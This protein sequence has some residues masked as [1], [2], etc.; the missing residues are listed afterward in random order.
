M[1]GV[2]EP[3]RGG[4]A[5]PAALSS[6]AVTPPGSLPAAALLFLWQVSAAARLFV[7]LSVPSPG[8]LKVR[9][10]RAGRVSVGSSSGA[11]PAAESRACRRVLRWQRCSEVGCSP[12]IPARAVSCGKGQGML[13]ELTP[14]A[15]RIAIGISIPFFYYFFVVVSSGVLSLK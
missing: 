10:P 5:G 2:P 3:A 8:A 1:P 9:I 7:T 14:P 6:M 11:G 15:S 12:G 13:P 4:S